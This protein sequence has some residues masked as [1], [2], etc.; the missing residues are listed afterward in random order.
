MC[1]MGPL[2]ENAFALYKPEVAFRIFVCYFSVCASLDISA[3]FHCGLE[4]F[5]W[6]MWC[7]FVGFFCVWYFV[8]WF[9]FLVGVFSC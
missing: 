3:L 5:F 1:A 6:R 2:L 7:S 8:V 9:F 4:V